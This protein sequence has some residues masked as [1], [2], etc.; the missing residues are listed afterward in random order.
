MKYLYCLSNNNDIHFGGY[1][2]CATKVND[3]Y[4]LNDDNKPIRIVRHD[5]VEK[6]MVMEMFSFLDVVKRYIYQKYSKTKVI[7]KK[8]YL[9]IELK[10]F[11]VL[12]SCVIHFF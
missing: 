2:I 6:N 3:V 4:H 1:Y 9:S 10:Y 5:F 8:Q 11:K 7:Q 12:I